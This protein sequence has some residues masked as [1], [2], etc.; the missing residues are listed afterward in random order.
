MEPAFL[1]PL[2]YGKSRRLTRRRVARG[3]ALVGALAAGASAF[4]WEPAL[5]RRMEAAAWRR[6]CLSYAPPHDQVVFEEDA[7]ALPALLGVGGYEPAVGGRV[8]LVPSCW[9]KEM[10]SLSSQG[11]VFLHA[12]TSRGGHRRLVGVDV[13]VLPGMLLSSTGNVEDQS[14]VGTVIAPGTGLGADRPVRVADVLLWVDQKDP[15]PMR[16]FA[17]RPDANDPSHFSF[18]YQR[19]GVRGVIQG[20]LNDDDTVTL[21]PTQGSVSRALLPLVW[22]PDAKASGK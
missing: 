20:W 8:R 14:I 12:L 1:T 22:T 18:D 10:P 21:A 16:F 2:E 6:E 9:R 11:T 7:A 3:L 19:A 4:W 15:R 5:A 17:G 13:S